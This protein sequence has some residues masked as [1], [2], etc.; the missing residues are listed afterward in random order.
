[1][2]RIER[3]NQRNKNKHRILNFRPRKSAK[4]CQLQRMKRGAEVFE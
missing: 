2:N 4:D 3:E 1:M